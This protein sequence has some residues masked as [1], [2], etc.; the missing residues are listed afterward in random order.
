MKVNRPQIEFV[1]VPDLT[2][3]QRMQLFELCDRFSSRRRN[4][5]EA[6]LDKEQIVFF[7]RGDRTE[8]LLG[9]GTASVFTVEYQGRPATVLYTGWAMLDPVARGHGVFQR[10]AVQIYAAQLR[11]HP[12]RPI[13]W[14]LLCS[15]LNSYMV[16]TRT[17]KVCYPRAD[18]PWPEREKALAEQA[19]VEIGAMWDPE[20]G[21]IARSGASFYR[22][23]QVDESHHETG[24]PDINFYARV[25]AGQAEG[26]TLVVLAPLDPSNMA[27]A[28][29]R[30]AAK[31]L[32]RKK[33]K[34]PST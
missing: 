33:R 8:H 9:F 15:T 1:D 2:H 26:D 12:L 4:R 7:V 24:D 30:F 20:T 5:F 14:L 31:T 3:E 21:V 28:A 18:R 23:G 11:A 22:E 13:Y 25:N 32:R 17:Y 27:D 6:Q 16:A 34:K 29:W 10:V 19:L